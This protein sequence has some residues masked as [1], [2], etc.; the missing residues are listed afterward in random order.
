MAIHDHD[1]RTC[2]SLPLA[3]RESVKGGRG[4]ERGIPCDF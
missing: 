1:D 2:F 3:S 4:G